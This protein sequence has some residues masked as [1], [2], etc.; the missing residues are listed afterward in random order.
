MIVFAV[1]APATDE[2]LLLLSSKTVP[3][4]FPG[5]S[6]EKFLLLTSV[7]V[8]TVPFVETIAELANPTLSPLLSVAIS[9]LTS[10]PSTRIPSFA[11]ACGIPSIFAR[12]AL[13][14]VIFILWSLPY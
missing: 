8:I 5:T 9:A 1:P 11:A 10:L 13:S 12:L 2:P 6:K 7:T 14:H 3:T 4:V